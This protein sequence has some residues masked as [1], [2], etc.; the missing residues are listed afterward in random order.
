MYNGKAIRKLLKERNLLQ[1]SLLEYLYSDVSKSNGSITQLENGNP[2]V[3]TLEKIADFFHVPIDTFFERSEIFERK[4]SQ[5]NNESNLRIDA[6]EKLI[7]EKD[8]RI[9]LLEQ[10]NQLLKNQTE[11]S[12]NQGQNSD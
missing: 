10:L 5:Q 1:K 2:T 9:D 7:A 12:R 11:S 4:E 8:K 6:L 3:K